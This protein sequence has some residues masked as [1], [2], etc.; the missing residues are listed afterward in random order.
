MSC[1]LLLAFPTLVLE[2]FGEEVWHDLVY[3][4][5]KGQWVDQYGIKGLESKTVNKGLSTE[6]LDASVT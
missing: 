5:Q 3:R 2:L 1:L 6:A 4:E